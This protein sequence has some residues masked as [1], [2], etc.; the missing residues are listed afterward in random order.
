M[1]SKDQSNPL[2]SQGVFFFLTFFLSFY[3]HFIFYFKEKEKI[4][5][6]GII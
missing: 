4:L 2:V 5:K 6:K 3:L 1:A